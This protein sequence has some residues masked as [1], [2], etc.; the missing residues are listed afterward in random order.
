MGSKETTY[1]RD[2]YSG[3]TK[4]RRSSRKGKQTTLLLLY[5]IHIEADHFSM[6]SF[7]QILL[8]AGLR[9]VNL[10]YHDVFAIC[11]ETVLANSRWATL[12]PQF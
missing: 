2:H 12:L 1:D 9:S 10:G 7:Q 4:C 3:A 5:G 8:M 6:V 11:V